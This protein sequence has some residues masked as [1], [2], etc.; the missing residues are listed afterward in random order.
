VATE[1]G[2]AATGVI[3]CDGVTAMPDPSD[4]SVA[5]LA[6]LGFSRYEA[7]TY[8]GLLAADGATGYGISN[9]TGVPQPKVYETLRRL[10]ERGAAVQTGERPARY[11]AVAPADLLHHL[12]GE[13][14]ARVA[15]ARDDLDRVPRTPTP[16]RVLAVARVDGFG[17]G[18]ERAAAAIAEARRRVY[19]HARTPELEPLGAA[20]GAASARG[21]EFAIVH[22]GPL[23]FAPPHGQ[24]VRHASTEGTLY[25]AR[26]TRHVAVVVDSAWALWAVARDGLEAEGFCA[27]SPLVAGLVKAYIRHDLFVQRI[28]Q[29]FTVELEGRYGPGLLRLADLSGN[30]QDASAE[31]ATGA[32]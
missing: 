15:A 27:D 6:E 22:F 3:E 1:P 10:V 4:P 23:P 5:R 11:T 8:V 21:V 13:F 17:L 20:I 25:P 18:L 29:D 16:E 32:W 26:K 14:Q 24:V 2:G 9:A 7:R 19:V 28:Y 12:E 30:A 31:R